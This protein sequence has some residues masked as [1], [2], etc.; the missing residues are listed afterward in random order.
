MV[1]LLSEVKMD[2]NL[3]NT[4]VALRDA[5]RKACEYLQYSHRQ[6]IF[7]RL[8]REI[9]NSEKIVPPIGLETTLEKTS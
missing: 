6:D 7:L 1:A 2:Q 8:K 3:K 5:A 9:E 4:L